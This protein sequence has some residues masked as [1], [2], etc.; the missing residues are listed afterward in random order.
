MLALC[1]IA[2]ALP[3]FALTRTPQVEDPRFRQLVTLDGEHPMPA[4]SDG[5]SYLRRRYQLQ[6]RVLVAAGLW[7]LPKKRDVVDAHVTSEV[8]RPGYTVRAVM[9]ETWPGFWLTGSLY[10][11]DAINGKSPAILSPHGHWS[12]GRLCERS[13]EEVRSEI[14]SGG[15]EDPAAARFHIQARC[16]Q[17]ARGGF[18]VFHYDM[19]G[20]GDSHQLNHRESFKDVSS[21]QFGVSAFGFQTW[22][23][24][25][26]LDYLCGLPEVD[27]DRIGVTGA[28][29]GGT[30][31]FI[32][33][34]IDDRPAAA[35]PAV[36]VSTEMQGGCECENAP[37]LRIGTNNVELAAVFAPRPLAMSAANDWTIALEERGMPWMRRVWDQWNSTDKLQLRTWPEYGHNFNQHARD[38]MLG[39]FDKHLIGASA[40]NADE[41]QFDP[42]P[43]AE[44]S[45]FASG[46]TLPKK[47]RD[48]SG[49]R[50]GARQFIQQR[51]GNSVPTDP[52]SLRSFQSD[53]RLA[54]Q[55]MMQPRQ[56]SLEESLPKDWLDWARSTSVTRQSR[57]LSIG[58]NDAPVSVWILRPPG[59]I[60]DICV[61]VSDSG[62]GPYLT[63]STAEH[64]ALSSLLEQGI[65]CVLTQVLAT[66]TVSGEEPKLP[67][68][69]RRHADYVG[70]TWGYNRTLLA[71]RVGDISIA[72]TLAMRLRQDSSQLRH[73]ETS[74]TPAAEIE[75]NG[76]LLLWGE[77]EAGPWAL[78]AAALHD[79][80]F[81]T[82]DA[83]HDL[84]RSV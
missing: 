23:S 77:G 50:A 38:S 17:L 53:T 63:P 83:N 30:Q 27:A 59:P 60:R 68:D 2:L 46:A 45:V 70:Y 22:N 14:A 8:T 48:L 6:L 1:S 78:M 36:M 34:A 81:Y 74:S 32:L 5:A 49:I 62:A 13:D 82:V 15:E 69:T 9:F 40:P 75:R 7:P 44:L 18:I 52:I 16:A 73:D 11:P 43:T 54:L 65:T 21:L 41:W 12:G 20:Y 66:G 42:I 4:L 29:G 76:K 35:F 39:W 61:I 71:E 58:S 37:Y 19:I 10:V 55:T 28:S 3:H 64:L 25:R 31:T 24:I 47:A 26:A 51:L 33:C 57:A 79:D 72:L 56:N 84:H 80:N 67:V